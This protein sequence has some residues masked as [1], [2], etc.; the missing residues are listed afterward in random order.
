[1]IQTQITVARGKSELLAEL[2]LGRIP[3][4]PKNCL[5]EGKFNEAAPFVWP[6]GSV[7]TVPSFVPTTKPYQV[8]RSVMRL[9]ESLDGQ[10]IYSTWSQFIALRVSR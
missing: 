8:R 5:R 3:K 10:G 9:V 1:M 6:L 7:L 4:I 2:V